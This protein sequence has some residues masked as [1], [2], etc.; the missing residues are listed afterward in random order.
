MIIQT[1]T[2]LFCCWLAL[3]SLLLVI[4]FSPQ[5]SCWTHRHPTAPSYGTQYLHQ[6]Q[7][8]P[9]QPATIMLR[10]STNTNTNTNTNT[11][12]DGAPTPSMGGS[13]N[14]SRDSQNAKKEKEKETEESLAKTRRRRTPS[15]LV[16]TWTQELST[17]IGA[18]T[19]IMVAGTVYG[20]L[21]YR[22][23]ALMVGFCGG[24]ILNAIVGKVLKHVLNIARPTIPIP[25]NIP[26]S[27]SSLPSS[28][29][30]APSKADT[31]TLVASRPK[32]NGMP[33]SH[34]MSLGFIGTFVAC[35][36]PSTT[37]PVL[38]YTSL[39]LQYRLRTQFHSLDQIVVGVV[40]GSLNGALWYHI[41][42]STTGI[43]GYTVVDWITTCGLLNP[44]TKLLPIY[45]LLVPLVMGALVVGSIER[46]LEGMQHYIRGNHHND[47]DRAGNTITKNKR[48]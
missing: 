32:D 36:V 39:S 2:R 38:L 14:N 16:S 10:A 26:T 33:S 20:V 34:G 7:Q 37:L 47:D 1:T 21:C 6:Q 40:L 11:Q 35:C 24:A 30:A 4:V 31:T 41:C 28:S 43:L 19:S 13:H 45:L 44:T 29:S 3:R 5:C 46:Q 48:H 15:V 9:Q 12:D 18:T 42:C 17:L 23:D 22:R 8:Q 27:S 25:T